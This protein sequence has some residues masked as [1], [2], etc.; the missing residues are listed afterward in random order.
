MRSPCGLTFSKLGPG[1]HSSGCRRNKTKAFLTVSASWQQKCTIRYR[2]TRGGE[3]VGSDRYSHL[4][5]TQLQYMTFI[6]IPP[7]TATT[8]AITMATPTAGHK[9]GKE[10]NVS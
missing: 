3:E 2:A 1:A 9:L 5:L 10:Q 8:A 4:F 6:R 7:V